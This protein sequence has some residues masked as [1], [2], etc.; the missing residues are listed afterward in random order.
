MCKTLKVCSDYMFVELD[1]LGTDVPSLLEATSLAQIETIIAFHDPKLQETN[2]LAGET[3]VQTRII[4]PKLQLSQQF[5]NV[6]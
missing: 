1:N 6:K 2:A 3:R 4:Q 5:K